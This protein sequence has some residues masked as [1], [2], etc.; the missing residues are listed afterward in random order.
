[1]ELFVRI[2][3]VLISLLICSN[4]FF[5]HLV[6]A[7]E[8]NLY[9]IL[10]VS[11]TATTKEI[12]SAYRRKALL[13]HPDKRKDISPEEAAEEFHRLVNAFE[14]LSDANTRRQYDQ[15][16]Q[17]RQ[18]NNFHHSRYH[19][20]HA[21]PRAGFDYK[22]RRK[23]QEAQS[24]V[25]RIRTFDQLSSLMLDDD[26]R[27]ERNLL[28]CFTT[29]GPGEE[30]IMDQMVYP[31]PFAGMSDGGV[32]FENI[33]Q[34]T[35]VVYDHETELTKFFGIPNGNEMRQKRQPVFL[36]G[37]RG[38]PLLPHTVKKL[39]TSSRIEF[40][41]WMWS[42]LE[43]TITFINR[44]SHPV[45][46]YWVDGNTAN[47]KFQINPGGQVR[48]N[49]MLSHEWWFKDYRVDPGELVKECTVSIFAIRSDEQDEFVIQ[50]KECFDFSAFCRDWKVQ[51][52]GCRDNRFKTREFMEQ[53]CPKTCFMCLDE[54]V[55]THSRG[56]E[57]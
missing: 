55:E 43:T 9:E 18:Q 14:V 11:R 46:A 48:V 22:Q 31:Y 4:C 13:S 39:H 25:M 5:L 6:C 32:W 40:E 56:D 35:L 1:M 26:D 21:P 30:F 57:F 23:I 15:Q 33:L 7:R 54:E 16:G 12:K 2:S 37:R 53:K 28:I 38:E 27:L 42:Q 8:E 47:K 52:G 44:H 34:T 24:R 45:I 51:G 3:A 20:H 41:N 49:S 36:F 10:D 50:P 17:Q 29:R 19:R